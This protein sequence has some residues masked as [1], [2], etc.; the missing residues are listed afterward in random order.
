MLPPTLEIPDGSDQKKL[1]KKWRQKFESYLLVSGL[2]EKDEKLQIA[3]F[4]TG[5]DGNALDV[6]NAL[7]FS[8]E[9]DKKKLGKTLELMEN[10]YVGEPNVVYER[11]L[12]FQRSQGKDES[13]QCF[14]TAVRALA[15]T[16]DFKTM[17]DEMVRDRIVC[18]IA[19][20]AT[21]RQLLQKKNL[22]LGECIELCRT[23]ETTATYVERMNNAVKN[24]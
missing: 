17:H 6:Y 4:I 22:T 24:Y 7:Q 13:F 16:C 11:Y 14:L 18:G 9:A 20:I 5:L 8:D 10:H 1:W 3:A 21:Q 2:S 19:N 12:F 23:A 15:T